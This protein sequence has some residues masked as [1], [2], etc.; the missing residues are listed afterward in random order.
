MLATF[1]ETNVFVVLR[2]EN[3][4]RRDVWGNIKNPPFLFDIQGKER[5]SPGK[6]IEIAE[7]LEDDTKKPVVSAAHASIGLALGDN[8]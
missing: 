1:L 3:L 5:L 8:W 2:L 6:A 4:H 7:E